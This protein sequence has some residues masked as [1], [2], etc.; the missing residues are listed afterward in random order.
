MNK[1][2]LA[3]GALAMLALGCVGGARSQESLQ[4]PPMQ[5]APPQGITVQGHSEIKE[6]PDVAR[7]TLSV[8]TN[9]RHSSDA[10]QQN[11]ERTS[12]VMASLRGA[13]IAGK[14]IQ[15]QSYT[16]QPTFDYSESPPKRKGYQVENRFEVTV[17]DLPKVGG[18]LDSATASGVSEIGSV[19]FDVS[20]R[21]GAEAQA[22]SQAVASAKQKAGV[23]ASAAGVD[24][25]RLLTMT[26][27]M[28]APPV[29]PVPLFAARSFAA[30]GSVPETPI[31]DQQIT[32]TA[33]ATLVYAMGATK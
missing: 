24:L 14:D 21:A 4:S 8:T 1:R 6:K 29:R 30:V 7:V 33:D 18:V 5:Y 13:G 26:E 27:S 31:A 20:D 22:L 12:A 28:A 11:A 19:S 25:G 23:M 10:V 2:I 3:A 16:V 9:A 17:R 32:V 15:T